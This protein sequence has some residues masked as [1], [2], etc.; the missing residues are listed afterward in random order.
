MSYILVIDT[1]NLLDTLDEVRLQTA[2]A[3]AVSLGLKSAFDAYPLLSE[4]DDQTTDTATESVPS[5]ETALEVKKKIP[6][7]D[8]VTTEEETLYAN[9]TTATTTTTN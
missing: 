3:A 5:N 9:K 2:A 7:K 6:L 1:K 8:T 4:D